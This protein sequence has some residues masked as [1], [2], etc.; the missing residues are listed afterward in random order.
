MP[1]IEFVTILSGANVSGNIDLTKRVIDAIFAP[2]TL[3]SGDLAVQGNYDTTSAGFLRMVG[4]SGDLCFSVG[5][6]SRMVPW[7]TTVRQPA[8]ARFEM[9]TAT[10]SFQIDT[11]TFTMVT[12]AR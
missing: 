11:K 1:P 2:V 6:G 9:L 8:Y 3:V 12:R 7:P 4:A 10:G 5:V